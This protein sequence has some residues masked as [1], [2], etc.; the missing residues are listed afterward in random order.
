MRYGPAEAG[1]EKLALTD[2]IRLLQ[3]LI[4][5]NLTVTTASVGTLDF[6]GRIIVPTLTRPCQLD[7]V[8]SPNS[9]PKTRNEGIRVSMI[10]N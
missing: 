9:S 10:P 5:G 2:L 7:I 8:L 3:S 6:S 1:H 4:S